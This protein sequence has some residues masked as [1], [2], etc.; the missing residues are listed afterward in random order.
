ML[1]RG[2]TALGR[3]ECQ[4]VVAHSPP[5]THSTPHPRS[6]AVVNDK[7]LRAEAALEAAE[8]RATDAEGT[9]SELQD[10]VR[11]QR[12]LI[13]KLEASCDELRTSAQDTAAQVASLEALVSH[14]A[15]EARPLV[16]EA[17]AAALVSH[18]A[19]R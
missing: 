19:A 7:V 6:A 8:A 5:P 4:V 2:S 11:E 9:A 12:A 17:A 16:E 13:E 3:H 15:R 1:A 10:T 14:I 18:G